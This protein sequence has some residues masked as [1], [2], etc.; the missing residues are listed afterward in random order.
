MGLFCVSVVLL[1]GYLS[2]GD[3]HHQDSEG[4]F[5]RC[6]ATDELEAR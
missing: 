5:G 1:Q 2:L 6:E 4:T 3:M